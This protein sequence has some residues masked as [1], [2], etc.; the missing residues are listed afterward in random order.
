MVVHRIEIPVTL[1]Q[2][3]VIEKKAEALNMNVA[4]FCRLLLLKSQIKTIEIETN[5]NAKQEG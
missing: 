1:E 4:E 2:K 3:K 5:E